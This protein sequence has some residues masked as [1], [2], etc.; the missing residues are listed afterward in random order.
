M[1]AV[2]KTGGK[3]YRVAVDDRLTI[4]RLA[5]N[6]GDTVEFGEVLA[7]GEGDD[8]TLG[9]P[10]VEGARVTAQVLEQGRDRTV[11]AFKKR[12]RQNSRRTRG[13]RQHETVVRISEILAA[14]AKSV[15]TQPAAKKARKPAAEAVAAPA[16]DA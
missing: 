10:L 11:I 13:H 8:V 16:E 7:F 1:F 2:I 3:Q 14:G 15:G 9:A 4:A 5:G 6:P 12:R